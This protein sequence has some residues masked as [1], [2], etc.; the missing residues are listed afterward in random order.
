MKSMH[1]KLNND[2]MEFIMLSSRQMLK[3]AKTSHLDFESSLIQQ[4]KLVKYLGG[5]LDSSLIHE[6]HIKQKSKAA[7]VKLHK[8]QGNKTQPQCHCLHYP[9]ANAM[10]FS[11]RLLKCNVI[12]NHQDTII[13]L[14]KNSKCVCK[15]GPQ[16]A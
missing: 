6:E 8:N 5:H 2:K 10:H 15:I 13:K 4:S 1:L 7:I 11:P 3:N 14:P 12:C 16:Q 9:S